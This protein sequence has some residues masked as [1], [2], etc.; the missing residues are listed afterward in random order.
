MKIKIQKISHFIFA[1][2]L[3]LH[4]IFSGEIFSGVAFMLLLIYLILSNFK[5]I[6]PNFN[7]F[8]IIAIILIGIFSGI[9]NGIGR[10]YFWDIW[11]FSKPVYLL[12]FG[13]ILAQKI[14]IY[15]LDSI[16][17]IIIIAG[18]I[19][20]LWHFVEIVRVPG[21]RHMSL[22]DIRE[23]T[24]RASIIEVI[25]LALILFHT[26]KRKKRL[27]L[28]IVTFGIFSII[29]LS[30][31]L[32]VSRTMFLML[33][34]F[35]GFMFDYFKVSFKSFFAFVAVIVGLMY[36]FSIQGESQDTAWGRL[37]HKIQKSPSEL[38]FSDDETNDKQA[39]NE[40][41]RGYEALMVLNQTLKAGP[42]AIC[43]GN[44]FGALVDL[45]IEEVLNGKTYRYIPVVHN[46]YAE[47][48]FKTGISG[49][50]IY[51]VFMIGIYRRAYKVRGL[52]EQLL[53][54]KKL[55]YGCII[56]IFLTTT[57]I[58]GIYNLQS[59]DAVLIIGFFS[60]SLIK[61]YQS[62]M[63]LNLQNEIQQQNKTLHVLS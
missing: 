60:F 63:K 21:W 33:F 62:L 9:P 39:V 20:A 11:L 19:S 2:L 55:V 7:I 50:I 12:F 31:L 61:R 28:K 14:N 23:Q 47:I 42:V 22:A 25:A 18:F 54:F 1:L 32:F 35:A 4:P 58:T 38:I 56:T 44:G 5:I 37:V 49:I 8:L 24:R 46:G 36:I 48:F 57:T 51:L 29:L 59:L 30:T 16:F 26:F 41:W 45:K 10:N 52:P 13:A 15:K 6:L 3:F 53:V 27:F 43:V 34:I 17:R 40:D